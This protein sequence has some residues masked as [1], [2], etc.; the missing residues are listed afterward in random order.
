MLPDAYMN[1]S[2][3]PTQAA[4]SWHGVPPER[5][6]VVHD[7]LDLGLGELR[8]K[9]GGSSSHNGVR[10][11]VRALGTR[12]VLRLRVGIGQPPGRVSGRD[13]VLSRFRAGEQ[14]EVDVL[15]EEAADAI[16]SL[17]TE[18]LAAT[19]NRYHSRKGATS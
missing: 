15:L 19:Q 6:V 12:D 4:V 17:V 2:G 7:E 5:V 11:V 16:E 1:E 9:L 10:D 8:C 18:G 3:G 14:D 13:H